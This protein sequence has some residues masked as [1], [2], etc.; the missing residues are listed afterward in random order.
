MFV[1]G[2][3]CYIRTSAL[4]SPI[5]LMSVRMRGISS[6]ENGL[7]AE[8]VLKI[9]GE[10]LTILITVKGTGVDIAGVLICSI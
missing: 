9:V 1:T 7:D 6:L 8:E 3:R 5:L 2:E 4:P 10:K